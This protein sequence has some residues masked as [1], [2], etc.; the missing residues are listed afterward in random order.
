[1]KI[2]EGKFHEI[3]HEIENDFPRGWHPKSVRTFVK[4][5]DNDIGWAVVGQRKC[6]LEALYQDVIRRL[7]SAV[8]VS[9]VNAMEYIAAE[10]G[11][12]RKL[13]KEGKDQ[14]STILFLGI[15]EV[16]VIVS[17]G[18]Q[19]SIAQFRDFLD[20]RRASR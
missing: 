14:V 5:V 10:I 8:V 20:H 19:S 2:W 3:L 15:P 9:H 6:L 13:R 18:R 12:S 4:R 11:T 1:M 7:V 17:H 16:E